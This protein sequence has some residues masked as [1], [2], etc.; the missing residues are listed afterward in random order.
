M[1]AACSGSTS[2]NS[3]L[4]KH[5]WHRMPT[6]KGLGKWAV[7]DLLDLVASQRS[8]AVLQRQAD[9]VL[10]LVFMVERVLLLS[11]QLVASPMVLLQAVALFLELHL[12]LEEEHLHQDWALPAQEAPLGSSSVHR[13]KQ[14]LQQEDSHLEQLL[15]SVVLEVYSV[16]QQQVQEHQQLTT[17]TTSHSI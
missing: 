3:K 13:Q 8:R 7:L 16:G 12:L 4:L 2:Y 17:L 6:R 10:G 14:V 9:S 1:R 5:E 11:L 15:N